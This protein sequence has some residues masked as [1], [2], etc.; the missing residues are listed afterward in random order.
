MVYRIYTENKNKEEVAKI[1]S[2]FFEGFTMYEGVGYWKGKE[3]PSLIIEILV[4]A[5]SNTNVYVAKAHVNEVARAI[6]QR[7]NQQAVLCQEIANTNW[8]I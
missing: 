1:V 4:E 7:N 5:D 6:K 2:F 8:L 3:E